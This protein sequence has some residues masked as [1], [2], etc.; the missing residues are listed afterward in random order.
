MSDIPALEALILTGDADPAAAETALL[1]SALYVVPTGGV[2]PKGVVLG[3]DRQLNLQ[4]LVL[5]DGEQAIAAF[6]RPELAKPVFGVDASHGMRG[7]HLLEAF[8]NVPVVINPGQPKGLALTITEVDGILER[9]GA[10]RPLSSDDK[11]EI[12]APAPVPTA[13]VSALQA[14]FAGAP[15]KA[16]WLGRSRDPKTGETGWRIELRG[17]IAPD[18]GRALLVDAL[19]PFDLG[20]EPIDLVVAS[21]EGVDAPGLKLI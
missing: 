19:R 3:R 2:I 5:P 1:S 18:Q 17:D 9:A 13:L 14:A 8:R 21:A 6:T 4:G 16:A 7:L 10:A 11:A 12:T 15:V 20:G